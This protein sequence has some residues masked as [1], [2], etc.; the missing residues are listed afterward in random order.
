MK[1]V[2]N[3]ET[4]KECNEDDTFKL[5][6]CVEKFISDQ[7]NCSLPWTDQKGEIPHVT[8]FQNCTKTFI[9]SRQ[10]T[11]LQHKRRFDKFP[12]NGQEIFEGKFKL[13]TNELSTKILGNETTK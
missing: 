7:I 3:V 4:P 12:Q 13:F 10:R 6:T 1:N 9:F 5:H 2:L 8:L 11:N